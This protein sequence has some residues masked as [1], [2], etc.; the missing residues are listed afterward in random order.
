MQ[1]W[2]GKLLS[3]ANAK[4][5][6]L[7]SFFPIAHRYPVSREWEPAGGSAKVC[8]EHMYSYKSFIFVTLF[9]CVEQG[10]MKSTLQLYKSSLLDK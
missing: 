5:H 1:D 9:F 6:T 10:L 4:K 3:E 8:T 2:D 7:P